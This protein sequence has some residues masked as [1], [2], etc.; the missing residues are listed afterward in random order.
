MKPYE[1]RL[2]RLL[3]LLIVLVCMFMSIPFK[4]AEWIDRRRGK[5]GRGMTD[6]E[7]LRAAIKMLSHLQRNPPRSEEVENEA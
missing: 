5:W 3:V 6:G 1:V 7:A 2:P 4:L